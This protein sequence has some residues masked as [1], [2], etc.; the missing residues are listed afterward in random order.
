M[1]REESGTPTCALNS[2]LIGMY[3]RN[4]LG[5]MRAHTLIH[6]DIFVRW[7]AFWFERTPC[8]SRKSTQVFLHEAPGLFHQ[9]VQAPTV[10]VCSATPPADNSIEQCTLND[11]E[12]KHAY[13]IT[14]DIEGPEP[15]QEEETALAPPV[16]CFYVGRPLQLIIQHHPQVFAGLN[17]LYLPSINAD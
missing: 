15:S 3:K 14:T 10:F 11:S 5:F 13:H 12:I 16:H 6:P 17:S 7:R 1:D 4:M 2:T 9:F 8:F